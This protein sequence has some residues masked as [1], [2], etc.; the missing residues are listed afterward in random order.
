MVELPRGSEVVAEQIPDRNP[1]ARVT[2]DRWH[3]GERNPMR[4]THPLWNWRCPGT[5]EAW[6]GHVTGV[7]TR[8][9]LSAAGTQKRWPWHRHLRPLRRTDR[10][11]GPFAT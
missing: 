3:G 1:L 2:V 9:R 11:A 8:D 7:R 10:K 4:P 5:R 6:K